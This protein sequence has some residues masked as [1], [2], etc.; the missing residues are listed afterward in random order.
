VYDLPPELLAAIDAG[1]DSYLELKEI[2]V[3]GTRIVVADEGRAVPWLA[4][5]ISAFANSDGG[6]LVLGVADDRR[7]VGV[8]SDSVDDLQGSAFD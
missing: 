3:E 4:R 8:P 2:V 5:Q 6:V 1:E 7:V